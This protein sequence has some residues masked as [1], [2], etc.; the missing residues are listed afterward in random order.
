MVSRMSHGPLGRDCFHRRTVPRPV[1][2][3]QPSCQMMVDGS[4]SEM[5]T[6][7]LS[8]FPVVALYLYTL[9]MSVVNFFMVAT[10]LVVPS[11]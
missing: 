3:S 10:C 6:C 4:S 5:M 9:M 7:G 11:L 1:T 2:Y 8:N